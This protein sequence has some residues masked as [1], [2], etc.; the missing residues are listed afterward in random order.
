M[1]NKK[2]S[3]KSLTTWQDSPSC[4]K[5]EGM[6][7]RWNWERS[8]Q[9]EQQRLR[10]LCRG[11]AARLAAGT[12]SRWPVLF[13]VV[14]SAYGHPSSSTYTHAGVTLI[15][16]GRHGDVMWSDLGEGLCLTFSRQES[17]AKSLFS[18]FRAYMSVL[19][20]LKFHFQTFC[21]LWPFKK[22]QFGSWLTCY[23]GQTTIHR[24][25]L[26]GSYW[27]YRLKRIIDII[28]TVKWRKSSQ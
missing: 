20:F 27:L 9:R 14:D 18:G 16:T 5:M 25:V 24:Y 22:G 26:K 7:L 28:S 10:G 15:G 4:E 8:W 11:L 23:S 3:D 6:F 17:K 21:L 12:Q 2:V 1:L 13:V 19:W